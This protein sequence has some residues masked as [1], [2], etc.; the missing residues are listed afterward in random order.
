MTSIHYSWRHSPERD[1]PLPLTPIAYSLSTLPRLKNVD[2]SIEGRNVD[3]RNLTNQL[4]P[5]RGFKNLSSIS[6]SSY[7]DIPLAYCEQEITPAVEASPGLVRFG[8]FNFC[9]PKWYHTVKNC[10]SLQSFL[11]KARPELVQLEL[12]QVPLRTTGLQQTLSR[13]LQHLSVLTKPGSR[14]VDF[15]W[16]ELWSVLKEARVELLTLTASG[17]ENTVDEMYAYLLSYTGL[18]KLRILDIQMDRQDLEES[19]GH[20]LWLQIVPHHKDSLTELA[21]VPYYEGIWCYG[22]TAAAAILQCSSLRNLTLSV[23]RVDSSWAKAKLSRVREND[24]V[25]FRDL[26]EPYCAPENCIVS[27]STRD[28]VNP[29]FHPLLLMPR[30]QS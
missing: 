16:A 26:E 15:A 7:G 25:E 14:G 19:A 29:A 23:C 6:L 17:S 8:I 2:I 28:R 18:Q 30:H 24:Q 4:P 20:R 11:E 1:S 13:K 9:T 5:L 21:V 12:K 22:P 3:L 10:A 27:P